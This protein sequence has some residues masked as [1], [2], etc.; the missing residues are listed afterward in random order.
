MLNKSLRAVVFAIAFALLSTTM[1][2]NA[3][4]SKRI[5]PSISPVVR[6]ARS[7]PSAITNYASADSLSIVARGYRYAPEIPMGTKVIA[8]TSWGVATCGSGWI[9]TCTWYWNTQLTRLFSSLIGGDYSSTKAT[10]A[11]AIAALACGSV[12]G[13]GGFVCAGAV[14][15]GFSYVQD[16]F[17]IANRN[18]GCVAMQMSPGWFGIYSVINVYPVTTSNKYCS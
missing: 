18:G 17:N 13:P 10:T 16:G 15:I 1:V 2:S 12:S 6:E 8:R 3:G 14:A 4:A 9:H 5:N 11:A 7:H